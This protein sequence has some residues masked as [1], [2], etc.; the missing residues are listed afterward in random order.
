[1]DVRNLAASLPQPFDEEEAPPAP[2]SFLNL[3]ISLPAIVSVL[4]PC[5]SPY[6]LH[7]SNA[8]SSLLSSIASYR[9][10]P[11]KDAM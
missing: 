2:R 7:S 9:S 6:V 11:S 5:L 4:I 3:V 1:M 10:H 8:V